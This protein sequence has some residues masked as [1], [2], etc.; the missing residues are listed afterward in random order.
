M[1]GHRDALH[2]QRA[3][4]VGG[5]GAVAKPRHQHAVLLCCLRGILFNQLLFRLPDEQRKQ[6]A[7]PRFLLFIKIDAV[8]KLQRFVAAHRS[9]R[10]CGGIGAVH[11][12]SG[13][14]VSV[15]LLLVKT[16]PLGQVGLLLPPF[17]GEVG[18][19]KKTVLAHFPSPFFLF[20]T[21]VPCFL[22]KHLTNRRKNSV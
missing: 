6:G 18:A 8:A 15:K 7:D 20:D 1:V 5:H 19:A 16:Y 11:V 22:S 2:R 17:G 3:Y 12:Q 13:D 21:I 4:G 14:S 10:K 9:S